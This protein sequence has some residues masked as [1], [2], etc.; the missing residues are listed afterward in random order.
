M[1]CLL[2]IIC[3]SIDELWSPIQSEKDECFMNIYTN[4]L[5]VYTATNWGGGW[6]RLRYILMINTLSIIN[7]NIRN[8]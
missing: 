8:Y 6:A 1:I 3:I 5:S 2:G 7:C 4:S